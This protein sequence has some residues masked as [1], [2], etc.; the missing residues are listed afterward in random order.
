MFQIRYILE[1]L[2][3]FFVIRNT[4]TLLSTSLPLDIVRTVFPILFQGSIRAQSLRISLDE[5]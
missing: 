3:D 4:P 5:V 2:R 1:D